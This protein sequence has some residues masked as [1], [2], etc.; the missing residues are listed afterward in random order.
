MTQ[1]TAIL[2]KETKVII[3]VT[4]SPDARSTRTIHVMAM[5]STGDLLRLQGQS[6]LVE[7]IEWPCGDAKE[8]AAS[9]VVYIRSNDR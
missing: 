4:T 1:T 6:Y 7:A 2:I 3:R 9:P 5:P 8:Q